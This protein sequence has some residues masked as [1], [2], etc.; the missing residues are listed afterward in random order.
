MG[1]IAFVFP[2][3][4]A[5]YHGMGKE[6]YDTSNAA[7]HVFQI[8]ESIRP[9]TI[10]QTFEAEK[11]EL[12][13]T[14][15]TQP[16]LFCVDLAA[17]EALKEADIIPS[18][19]A[20][21]SLGE[22]AALA[23]AEVFNEGDGFRFVCER[24]EAMQRAALNSNGEMYAVLK[25][26]HTVIEEIC[27]HYEYI[28]PVNYNSPGQLVVA[29]KKESFPDF[30]KEVNQHKGKA[31]KLPVS[32]GFHSPFMDTAVSDLKNEMEKY[33][34]NPSALPVYANYSALPYAEEEEQIKDML[35]KQINHP[36]RWQ[37]LIENMHKEGIDTFIEVG[38]GKVLSK[39]IGRILPNAK[40]YNVENRESL[41][42]TIQ[43]IK[44]EVL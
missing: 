42:H 13:E 6:L 32:G 41:H 25:L 38:A 9:G 12:S 19:V 16:C 2:G 40:I 24:A 5:Q 28:Y 34:L 43:S 30:S 44:E 15:N 18:A 23:F 29:G 33:N 8:A 27:S 10:N 39:L 26:D 11:E 36:V 31:I 17:A 1:K 22:I 20:G 3:Q 7:K 14:I 4:G 21:F 37:Q 35:L